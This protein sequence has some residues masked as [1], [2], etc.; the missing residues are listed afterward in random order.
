MINFRSIFCSLGFIA[1]GL[2]VSCNNARNEEI[3]VIDNEDVPELT[4]TK[5][6]YL[7]I[8]FDPLVSEV[9][10]FTKGDNLV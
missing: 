3:P 8:A 5:N 2:L 9:Y 1:A 6:M 4:E 10:Y 7:D